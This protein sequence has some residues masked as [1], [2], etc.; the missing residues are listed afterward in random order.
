MLEVSPLLS[1]P[2]H[3]L[4]YLFLNVAQSVFEH[5]IFVIAA[6]RSLLLVLGDHANEAEQFCRR[7]QS[8]TKRNSLG[9]VWQ[10]DKY[11]L[12]N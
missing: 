1:L 10:P 12:S 9:L 2:T 4:F 8:G 6:S 3:V 5:A 11:F 7:N